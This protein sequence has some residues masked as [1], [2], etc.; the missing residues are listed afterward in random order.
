MGRKAKD[1]PV[2]V[3]PVSSKKQLLR[4]DAVCQ[5][6]GGISRDSLDS[7]R[8]DPDERFPAPLQM[9]GNT[10]MWSVE[11][12]ERYVSRKEKDVGQMSA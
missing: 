4:A 2:T 11:Q 9:L 1:P 10:P 8:N 7:I 6:L 12:L 5:F 3:A